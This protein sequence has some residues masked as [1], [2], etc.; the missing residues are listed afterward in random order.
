MDQF[1]AHLDRGWDLVQRGD[2]RGAELSARRALELDADSP[3]AFNL[4][5]YVAALQGEFEDAVEHYQQAIALDDCYLEAMLNAAEILIHP[6]GD[7]DAAERMCEDALDLAESDDERVD[8]LL[9]KFDSLLG[10]ELF[11]AAKELCERFPPGPYENPAH[12][13]LVGRAFYEIGEVAL[14]VPLIE[15]AVRNN[16]RNADAFYYLALVFDEQGRAPEAT[17]AFLQSRELDL[18]APKPPWA[19]STDVFFAAAKRAVEAL[20]PELR[21]WVAS[22]QLYVA[23]MP[24]VEV[25]LDGVDPR[26][27]LLVDGLSPEDETGGDTPKPQSESDSQVRVIV[28]RRNL[29]RMAG[30]IELIEQEITD[31]LEHELRA[32]FSGEVEPLERPKG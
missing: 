19:V 29:E 13:F 27:V 16:S 23:D 15:E 9:L 32:H 7:F 3:E 31:A 26:A 8:A 5:G 25:V 17:R 4:L 6:L 20:D 22:E 2:P 30:A 1:S 14:A 18:E 28:Y 12:S 11:D 10:R 21:K 24:G